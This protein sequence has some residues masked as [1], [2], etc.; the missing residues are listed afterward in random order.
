MTHDMMRDDADC[1]FQ[2][3]HY[4]HILIVLH[5]VSITVIVA[6]RHG[7]PVLFAEL[8]HKLAEMSQE[9]VAWEMKVVWKMVP[10]IS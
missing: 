9:C 8:A 3:C 10:C 7:V 2:L 6:Y 5:K 4:Q 1:V